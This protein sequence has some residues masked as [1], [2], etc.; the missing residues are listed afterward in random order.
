MNNLFLIP[1]WK[2]P[3]ITEICLR[4]LQYF[5]QGILAIV[6]RTDDAELCYRLNVPYCW[7]PNDYLGAKWNHGL[8]VAKSKDWDYIVTLGSDDIVKASLFDFYKSEEDIL[9]TDKIHFIEMATGKATLTTRCRV[10]AGRRISRKVIEACNYKLWTPE[11]NRSLDMDSNGAIMKAGFPCIEKRTDPH[12]VG[13]KSDV[14]IWTY[15]H[16]EMRGLN[17][18][19]EETLIGVPEETQAMIRQLLPKP[20]EK[21]KFVLN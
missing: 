13:L 4:N 5:E 9:I 14:N 16:L 17:V 8:S 3:E 6:S 12:I 20:I 19:Q 2:R 18:R 1:I 15:Q 10:G 7:Y 21:P 11:K